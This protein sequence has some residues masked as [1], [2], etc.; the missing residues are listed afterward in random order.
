MEKVKEKKSQISLRGGIVLDIEDRFEEMMAVME[1][2]KIKADDFVYF[3]YKDGCRAA[4]RKKDIIS[5]CEY[6]E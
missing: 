6:Y 4:V 5:V 3:K 2:D 1:N